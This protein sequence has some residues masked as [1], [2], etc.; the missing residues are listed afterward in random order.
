MFWLFLYVYI[1]GTINDLMFAIHNEV[2][3]KDWRTHV[4][5]ALWPLSVPLAIIVAL[6]IR[7]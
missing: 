3:L 1:I 2:D 4:H 6:F 5:V 7:D